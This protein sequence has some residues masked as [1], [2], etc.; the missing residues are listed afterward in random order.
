MQD[1]YEHAIA[2]IS[3]DAAPDSTF[4]LDSK[5]QLAIG[6]VVGNTKSGHDVYVR[7]S[8]G[9]DSSNVSHIPIWE[10]DGRHVL[11]TRAWVL[12]ERILSPRILH[13]SHSETAW[14]CNTRYSCECTV[15]PREPTTRASRDVLKQPTSTKAVERDAWFALACEYSTRN[16]IFEFDSLAS[17]AAKSFNKTYL[18]GLW[19]EDLPY[20]LLWSVTC[21]SSSNRL[22]HYFP[23]WSWAA[24]HG[25]I[26]VAGG[27]FFRKNPTKTVYKAR[28]EDICRD[29]G[30]GSIYGSI[31]YGMITIKSRIA[32]IGFDDQY[33]AIME[34]AGLTS[35][36]QRPVNLPETRPDVTDWSE[37]QEASGYY[38]F[39][40]YTF[41]PEATSNL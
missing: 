27:D 41:E 35:E 32:P 28:I 34:T 38:L 25:R 29:Y 30:G 16:L 4:R 19:K 10:Q 11:D 6:I 15:Q 13:F 39:I 31:L 3:A 9:T 18:A 22:K 40:V 37:F 24:I 2:N 7:P 1:V 23:S 36:T 17:R 33:R 5:K 12:Q 8:L 21:L 20:C 26:L 14:E